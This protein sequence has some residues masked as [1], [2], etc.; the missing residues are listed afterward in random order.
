MLSSSYDFCKKVIKKWHFHQEKSIISK[1]QDLQE[2]MNHIREFSKHANMYDENTP[3]QQEVARHLVFNIHTAPLKILDLG[4]GSGAVHQHITWQIDAFIGVDCS[5]EMTDRHP[6]SSTIKIFNEDFD[7]DSLWKKLDNSY[8]MI[9][10]S[11]ALQW[12]KDIEK[13]LSYIAQ[14]SHETAL[15]IFTDKTF[16]TLYTSSGLQTFLPNKTTLIEQCEKYFTFRYEI[17]TFK[18]CFEDTRSLFQY[19]KKSGV[20][21]GKKQLSMSALKKLMQNYPENFLEFEV[22][23]IWGTSRSF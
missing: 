9:I 5:K 7:A 13:V 17:K 22:L 3:I 23:F 19:I 2:T 14:T 21:G 15:A 20:S 1:R 18:L 10:S 8:D 4:C 12:S 6:K 11:S 16:Q